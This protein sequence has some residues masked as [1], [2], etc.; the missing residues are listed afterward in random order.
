MIRRASRLTGVTPHPS[1]LEAGD[2]HQR[3]AT[4]EREREITDCQVNDD[5]PTHITDILHNVWA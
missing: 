4:D 5:V 1:A 3:K 2:A